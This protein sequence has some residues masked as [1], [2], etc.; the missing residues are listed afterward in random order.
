[1]TRW[2]PDQYLQF[3]DHRLRPA[4]E[5]MARIPLAECRTIWDLGCGAGN[6]TRLLAERWPGAKVTG[7]DSS[8]EMLAKARPIAGVEWTTGDIGQWRPPAPA[9]L[10]FS[11]AALHWLDDHR[12]LFAR[13]IAGV[14]KGGVLAVQM[15]RNFAALSHTL[16]YETARRQPWAAKLTPLLRKTPVSAPQDYYD[17]LAP[18]AAS[19]DIWETEYLHVLAGDNAVVEWTKG[20]A[21]RPFLDALDAGEQSAFLAAYTERMAAA[22]PQ[23]SDG[24][25]LF[26]FRRL[27]IVARK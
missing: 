18:H 11:N 24:T 20:T 3:A 19:L 21:V 8:A 7:V 9:D 23:R 26:P 16:L 6:V 25:T 1:M 10:V 4:L 15:P 22:Y 12:G 13:L 27:F 2:D 17:W 14:V 5:L